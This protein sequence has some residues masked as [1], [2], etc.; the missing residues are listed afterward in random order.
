MSTWG[1]G[2]EGVGKGRT[3]EQE[4]KRARKEQEIMRSRRREQAA[5]CIV[6][7][8]HLGIAR[9]LWDGTYL[10]VVR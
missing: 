6:G 5:P 7:Q 9:Q 1:G 10:A 2:G 4:T 3:R 8:A